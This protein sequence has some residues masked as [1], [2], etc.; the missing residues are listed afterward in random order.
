MRP[1]IRRDRRHETNS[2]PFGLRSVEF[3]DQLLVRPAPVKRQ[4]AKLLQKRDDQ[5]RNNRQEQGG[6]KIGEEVRLATY[7]DPFFV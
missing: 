4:R 7:S 3:T 5:A 2:K 1:A 6:H